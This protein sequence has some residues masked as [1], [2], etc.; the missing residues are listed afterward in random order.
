MHEKPRLWIWGA[1][2]V[3]LPGGKPGPSLRVRCSGGAP[4]R[5]LLIHHFRLIS[6]AS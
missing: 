3:S 1:Q 2:A 5:T 6:S 4:K